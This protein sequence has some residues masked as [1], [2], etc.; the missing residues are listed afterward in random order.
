MGFY[1]K[2]K[3]AQEAEKERAMTMTSCYIPAPKE[4][5]QYLKNSS[6]SRPDDVENGVTTS[7]QS[8]AIRSVSVDSKSVRDSFRTNFNDS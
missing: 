2:E 1:V 6:S 5:K 8:T 4:M 3:V 7:N